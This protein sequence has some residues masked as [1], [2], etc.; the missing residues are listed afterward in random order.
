MVF[1]RG[2]M[3]IHQLFMTN[4]DAEKS[5]QSYYINKA[6]FNAHADIYKYDIQS[7]AY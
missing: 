6:T 1:W 3:L 7:L 4:N 2:E 5:H